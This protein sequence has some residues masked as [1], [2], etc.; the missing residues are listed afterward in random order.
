MSAQLTVPAL[1][2]AGLLHR[3]LITAGE[4]VSA[5]QPVAIVVTQT[6][7][8]ALPAS[9]GGVIAALLIEEGAAVEGASVLATLADAAQAPRRRV[10]PVARR[11]AAAQG[12]DLAAL[13]GSGASGTICKRDVV[14]LLEPD[15]TADRAPAGGF[16]VAEQM[17]N[18]LG[19]G[20]KVITV[21]APASR[22]TPPA[23]AAPPAARPASADPRR[24]T[25]AP[26]SAHTLATAAAALASN[27]AIPPAISAIT[28]DMA[29]IEQLCRQQAGPMAR[30]GVALNATACLALA[31]LRALSQHRE[32][33]ATWADDE[34]IQRAAF[35]LAV[36]RQ[37]QAVLLSNAADLS[38]QGIA[39][40]LAQPQDSAG[41]ATF[42]LE[43]SAA[44]WWSGALVAPGQAAVL[45]VGATSQQVGVVEQ[46]GIAQVVIRPL[47]TL[48]LAYDA[49]M[50]S[51]A[52]A[53]AFLGTLRHAI[54]HV[55]GA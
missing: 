11:I 37:G 15:A 38:L 40:A 31:A 12:I 6:Q 42:T 29:A 3:W 55:T 48:T 44:S 32:L 30:R 25:L 1:D 51:D 46:G 36:L 34:I 49:R 52:A 27:Q 41:A 7:E 39:R 19:A 35:N 28:V 18:T 14:A 43:H 2:S 20:E 53:N 47:A 50:I 17:G 10:T 13:Q 26:H 5:G 8:L 9:Q 54:E 4:S 23:V 33:L 45:H 22:P 16:C 21:P 24:P